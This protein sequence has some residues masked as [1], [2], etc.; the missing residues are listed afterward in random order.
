MPGSYCLIMDTRPWPYNLQLTRFF[1]MPN[2]RVP[3]TRPWSYSR[4][5]TVKV[6]RLRSVC[7]SI[8]FITFLTFSLQENSRRWEEMS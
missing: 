6:T 7:K 4:G 5:N 2:G 8:L 3:E 1:K